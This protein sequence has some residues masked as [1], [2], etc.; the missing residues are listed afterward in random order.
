MAKRGKTSAALQ[1][2]PCEASERSSSRPCGA[3]RRWRS[4][5]LSDD[6]PACESAS[7]VQYLKFQ[8]ETLPR[9]DADSAAV[10]QALTTSRVAKNDRHCK[11]EGS[12]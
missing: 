11:G 8:I 6:T 7:C 3:I 10:S 2:K 5:R 12:E 1:A 4:W 9:R